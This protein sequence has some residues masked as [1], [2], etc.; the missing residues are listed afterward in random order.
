MVIRFHCLALLA[1]VIVFSFTKRIVEFLFFFIFDFRKCVGRLLFELID[2]SYY[3]DP[4]WLQVG[5][6]LAPFLN[7]FSTSSCCYVVVF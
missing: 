5:L 2:D 3:C 7:V 4:G 1:V 6:M